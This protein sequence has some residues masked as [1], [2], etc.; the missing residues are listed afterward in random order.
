MKPAYHIPLSERELQLLGELTAIQG[1]ID[2]LLQHVIEK[3]L[4]IGPGVSMKVLGST[5]VRAN[6]AVFDAIVA[7]KCPD[8]LRPLC[9]E[10]SADIVTV[11]ERRNDFIHAYYGALVPLRDRPGEVLIMGP[12]PVEQA[13][14]AIAVRPRS[15]KRTAMSELKPC[16]DLAAAV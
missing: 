7:E 11:S 12:G 15:G 5:Q 4:D 13:I 10:V 16:R 2:W 3:L 6:M 8:E 1:Q 9:A 14:S